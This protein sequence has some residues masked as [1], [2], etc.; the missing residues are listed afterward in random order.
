MYAKID[1]ASAA[2]KDRII[3][4]IVAIADAA[5]AEP[6]GGRLKISSAGDMREA[7]TARLITQPQLT[8]SCKGEP[9][10][11]RARDLTQAITR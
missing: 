4:P 3:E 5:H 7:D 6:F 2:W 1:G 10:I 11:K 9:H 8:I